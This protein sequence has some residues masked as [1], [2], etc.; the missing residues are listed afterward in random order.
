[1]VGSSGATLL[2]CPRLRQALERRFP[3]HRGRFRCRLGDGQ[4][5]PLQGRGDPT[6][7]LAVRGSAVAM[8]AISAQTARFAAALRSR[9]ITR[10][11]ASQLKI[12]SAKLISGL[13]PPQ[14]EHVLVDANQRSQTTSSPPNQAV[15]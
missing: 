9:S 2:G 15:L 6:A 4:R 7:C 14:A 10:P 13:R 1:M 5:L 11:H 3:L 12:R 8:V